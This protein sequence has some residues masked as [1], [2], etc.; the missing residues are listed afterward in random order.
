MGAVV[1]LIQ[2]GNSLGI[3]LSKETLGKLNVEKGD[4]LYVSDVP[5]GIALSPYDEAAGKRMAA[6]EQVM[7]KRRDVLRK[8]A[9]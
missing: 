5:S 4:S 2:V 3:I 7:R 9:E 8:L 6:L 1:K